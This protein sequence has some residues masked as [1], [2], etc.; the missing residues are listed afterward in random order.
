[1]DI[2]SINKIFDMSGIALLV[3]DADRK[4]KY[5]NQ[6]F[7][8][9][10]QID[11][12]PEDIIGFDCALAAKYAKHLFAD[13]DKFEIDIIDIPRKC[14]PTDEIIQMAN[15]SYF[16]RMYSKVQL[17]NNTYDNVWVYQ[18]VT[19]NIEKSLEVERQ[20]EFYLNILNEIPA[21]I[22]IFNKNHQYL[23]I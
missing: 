3:E 15:G 4:I 6:K 19:I 21:D 18:D 7:V 9:I 2:S 11:S 23:Y 20:K 8:E 1:M 12:K 16:K 17:E 14:L 10:M 5:T 13:P 22:A